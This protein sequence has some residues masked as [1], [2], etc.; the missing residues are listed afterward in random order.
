MSIVAAMGDDHIKE[1]FV[2]YHVFLQQLV[3][4]RA[5]AR[6]RQRERWRPSVLLLLGYMFVFHLLLLGQIR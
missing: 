4:G 1:M 6:A 3:F 2:L 5:R